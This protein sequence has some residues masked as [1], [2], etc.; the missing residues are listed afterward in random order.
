MTEITRVFDYTN[1][2]PVR[3]VTINNEPWFV[4]ADIC[5]ALGIARQQDATRYLDADERQT[6]DI[7]TVSSSQTTPLTSTNPAVTLVN[8]PGMYTL[9]LRSRKPEAKAFKRWITHD[10]LPAIRTHGGYVAPWATRDQLAGLVDLCQAQLNMIE[11]A[12]RIILDQAW[13]DAKARHVIARGLGEQPDIDHAQRPLTV[14]EY[15]TDRDVTGPAL[16]SISTQFGKHLKTAY[17]QRYGTPPA[18]VERFISGALRTVAGYN[19]SHRDLFDAVWHAH[20][21]DAAGHA[22]V[23]S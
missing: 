12:R 11:S 3:T 14:G 15:L 23:R 10:V 9:I 5:N 19:E 8:E 17:T 21:A 4:A 22:A 16:R 18:T 13:L 7:R 20:Y 2:I 6:I 1:G